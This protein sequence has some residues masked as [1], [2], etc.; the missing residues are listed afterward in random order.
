MFEDPY[1]RDDPKS[2]A[3]TDCLEDRAEQTK[4]GR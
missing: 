4:E 1:E 2:A 3:W